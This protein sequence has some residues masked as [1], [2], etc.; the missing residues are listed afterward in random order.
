MNIL[1]TKIPPPI[2]ALTCIVINYLSTYL[3]NPIKLPKIEII[4][5]LILL[6]GLITAM[7]AIFLFKKNKTIVNPINPKEATTLITTGIFSITRNPMYL[8]LFLSFVV[9]FYSL[10]HGLV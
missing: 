7:L 1:K 2:I 8:G 3:I 9:Q 4:G 6:V 10:V 5:I